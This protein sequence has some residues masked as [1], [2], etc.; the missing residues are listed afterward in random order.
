MIHSGS[1]GLGHQ[2]CVLLLTTTSTCVVALSAIPAIRLLAVLGSSQ[3]IPHPACPMWSLQRTCD[4][5]CITTECCYYHRCVQTTCLHVIVPWPVLPCGWLTG[6]WQQHHSAA[7]RDRTT[8]QQWQQ[9]QT[10]RLQT[11]ESGSTLLVPKAAHALTY[12]A[13]HKAATSTDTVGCHASCYPCEA[14][15]MLHVCQPSSAASYRCLKHSAEMVS[16]ELL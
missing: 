5:V 16:D 15:V 9:Q 4:T 14:S 2:V 3:H 12:N 1:R 13:A 8:W 11:G 7:H 6:N 10:L